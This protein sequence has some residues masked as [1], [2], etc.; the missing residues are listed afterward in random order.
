[1]SGYINVTTPSSDYLAKGWYPLLTKV[2]EIVIIF[3]EY[4]T[5][6]KASEEP[7]IL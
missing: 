4:G 7:K 5:D 3:M 1:M 6:P 2:T